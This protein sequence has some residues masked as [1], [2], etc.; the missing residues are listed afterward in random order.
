[1][2][3]TKELQT[4]VCEDIKSGLTPQQCAQKYNVPIGLIVKWN[5][6]DIPI[7]RAAEIAIRKY[8]NEVSDIETALTDDLAEYFN[9]DI[10]DDDYFDACEK[11]SK[12]LYKLV[13]EVVIKERQLNPHTDED[14]P[15][16]QKINEIKNK[17]LNN[18][19]IKKYK[20]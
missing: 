8:Q 20:M 16:V 5:S 9:T 2:R 3:Y 10:S 7:Q 17:W 18:E 11:V 12:K 6:L 14:I 15:D 4:K 13:A 1:M 19:V